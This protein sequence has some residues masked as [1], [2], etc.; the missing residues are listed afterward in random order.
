MAHCS[1]L[2]K[3]II[4]FWIQCKTFPYTK[5]KYCIECG[6]I[7]KYCIFEFNCKRLLKYIFFLYDKLYKNSLSSCS[8]M[9]LCCNR[10][11]VLF[12][13]TNF[14]LHHPYLSRQ[15]VFSSTNY[16]GFVLFTHTHTTKQQ[17]QKHNLDI[18]QQFFFSYT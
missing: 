4:R 17:Q 6:Q 5:S 7:E 3:C 18:S 16:Y 11:F 13:V 15:F 8:S 2:Y 14:T 1:E 12:L 10:W 9:V